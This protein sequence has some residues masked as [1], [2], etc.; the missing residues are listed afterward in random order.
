IHEEPE[1]AFKEY[2]AHALLTDYLEKKGF[3]V[4]RKAF[5]L[6]TAFVARAGKSDKVTI[7]FCSEYDALPGIGH[8]CG[9][10]LIAIAG[11]AAAIGVKAAIKKFGLHAQV[12]LF[13]TPA[14]ETTGGKIVMLERGAFKNVDVCMMLHGANADLSYPAFLAL[15]TAEVEFFGKASHASATPWE[16]VNAL[17]A[18]IMT[19]TSIGLM[20][21]QLHPTQRVHGIIKDGGKA[22][23]IIPDYTLSQYTVRALKYSELMVLKKRVEAIFNAAARS[24]GCTVSIKWGVPYKDILTN[25]VLTQKFEH[26]M[27]AQGAKYLPKE[28]QLRKVGGSTDMGN[29]TYA[30]PGIH[31]VFNILNLESKDVNV[32]LHTRAFAEAAM[33]PIAHTATLRAAKCLAMTGVECILDRKLLQKVKKEFEENKEK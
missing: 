5:G 6:D 8:G 11:V 33:Q 23:N 14:E 16:G 20:R 27:K 21:Q 30:L 28:E 19:Y 17:D 22:A 18:A 31:P 26:Y 9:H 3:K 13:G 10:N 1:L 7:G 12:K 25:S 15:D 2:K 29:L 32:A 24:T 4:E